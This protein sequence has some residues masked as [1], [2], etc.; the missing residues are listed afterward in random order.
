MITRTPSQAAPAPTMATIRRE[1]GQGAR[2]I[3]TVE[4]GI[5]RRFDPR[6]GRLLP[7][8]SVKYQD[9]DGKT[10]RES[11]GSTSIR[12]ARKL[13]AHRMDQAGRGEPG[14]LA[15]RLT[16]GKLLNGVLADYELNER[17]SLTTARARLRSLCERFGKLSAGRLTTAEVKVA[18]AEWRNA[19]LT[20]ATVN[21]RTN[22]LRR[23]FRLAWREGTL[24]RVPY[25][26]RL[27]EKS[28]RGLY[29]APADAA[30]IA[31]SLP[32]H[33]VDPFR[34]AYLHGTRKGQLARTRRTFVDLERAVSAW[35]ASEC[36]H[37]EPHVIPLEG[38][39]LAIVKR[40]IADARLC[41]PFLWHGPRCAP[42][43]TPPERY[44]CLGNLRVAFQKACE[45]AGIPIGRKAGGV[46]FHCTRNSAVTNLR[47]GGMDESD[48]MRIT[49]HRTR[50]V[51]ARY[52]LTNVE[53]LR[54]RLTRARQ[55]RGACAQGGVAHGAAPSG[56]VSVRRVL[57]MPCIGSVDA[58]GTSGFRTPSR[59]GRAGGPDRRACC[60]AAVPKPSGTGCN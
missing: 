24:A 41:C 22:L 52:D 28:P 26:P 46:V 57:G 4:P 18:H 60:A 49:G 23:A 11:T 44:G 37:N 58:R 21:R 19:G 16:V 53:Q 5:F 56:G 31:E 3:Q 50:E 7:R 14:R 34:F 2:T 10:I 55:L 13:R 39:G 15:E 6:S 17:G 20:A 40:A 59:G 35:P 54:E 1:Q 27:E 38:E 25:M 9:A 36:K 43:R 32:L 8:L 33:A 42:G 48:G 45:T 51:F 29:I 30:K 47:Y 12:A